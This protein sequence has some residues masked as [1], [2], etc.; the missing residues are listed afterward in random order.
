MHVPRCPM[1]VRLI[2]QPSKETTEDTETK[3]CADIRHRQELGLTKYGVAVANNKLELK[4]WMQH[5]YT[6]ALD[7]A[8]YLKRA[9]DEIDRETKT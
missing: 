9:M 4:E 8:I 1:L 2:K 7:L 3:V 5:A 6:E